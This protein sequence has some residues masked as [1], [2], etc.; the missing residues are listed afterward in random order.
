[1]T[2]PVRSMTRAQLVAAVRTMQ[3]ERDRAIA[4]ASYWRDRHAEAC[5]HLLDHQCGPRCV[6]CGH[7][8]CEWGNC[9]CDCHLDAPEVR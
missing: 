3:A 4:R 2:T 7:D 8:T 1:M 5:D 6:P 9:G